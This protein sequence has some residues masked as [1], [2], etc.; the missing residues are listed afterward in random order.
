MA[1]RNASAQVLT[2][3]G[4]TAVLAACSTAPPVPDTRL[5]ETRR[6][7]GEVTVL[8][9]S[10]ATFWL[11]YKASNATEE[12]DPDSA[13]AMLDAGRVLLDLRCSKYLDDIGMGNQSA[14]NVRQQIG[15][16][17]G[18]ASALMGITGSAAK[19]VAA[20]ASAFSFGGSS[21][22]AYTT[23]YLFADAG[24]SVIK[25]VQ[26]AQAAYWDRSDAELAR[27]SVNHRAAVQALVGYESI[28][29]PAEIRAL[30]RDSIGK[31]EIV[32]DIEV[33]NGV[34]LEVVGLLARMAQV[35]QVPAVAEDE[36]LALYARY[37]GR[38]ADPVQVAGKPVEDAKLQALAPVF[39]PLTLRGDK[40]GRRWNDLLEKD[41]ARKQAQAVANEKTT[42]AASTAQGSV[43]TVNDVQKRLAA[44]AAP[45]AQ[46][47]NSVGAAGE[48]V[49]S[50][51]RAVGELRSG[52]TTAARV[53]AAQ[54]QR[55]AQQANL[56]ALTASA[57]E[58][59][60]L[61]QSNAAARQ[62]AEQVKAAVEAAARVQS[63]QRRSFTA[64]VLSVR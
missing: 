34:Q 53:S 3:L 26:K 36:A 60:K 40:V 7:T 32:A 59:N 57:A 49:R 22:D 35:L 8:E 4:L 55:A 27:V 62:A 11:R 38:G 25:L 46:A 33:D 21:F 48:A 50:A 64:P 9:E 1:H 29:R 12:D 39:A 2:V 43:A 56:E 24:T 20:V 14:S 61:A 18:L 30:I 45:T 51:D 42:E 28:C 13:R 58:Q 6:G 23:A 63:V 10:L 47:T 41:K 15:L 54:A 5:A 44:T 37:L 52:N 17:G 16:T 31:A 19:E